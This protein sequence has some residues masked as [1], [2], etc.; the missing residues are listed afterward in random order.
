M[1]WHPLTSTEQLDE[2]IAESKETPVIIFKHSTSCSIS[3]TAKSRIERQWGSAGLD[4]VK[5]YFLDLIRY[6]PVSQE[7]ADVLQV[8][9]QSP[10]ILLV[11]DGICT[12]DASH[13]SIGVDALKKKVTA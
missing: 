8:Q 7:V 6:R 2:I 1:N 5:T 11:Q 4:H 12:Y 9:H 3:A 13:M 10:Q